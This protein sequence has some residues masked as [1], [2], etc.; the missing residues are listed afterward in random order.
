M[1]A[2]V[3]IPGLMTAVIVDGEAL[4]DAVTASLI[5]GF[6]VTLSASTAIYGMATFAERRSEGRGA[7]ALVGAFIGL[8]GSIVFV[9]AIAVG[10]Y[11]MVNG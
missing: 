8:V 7:A 1:S 6:I 5:A 2:L 9:G 4:L 10:L 3:A 11:V